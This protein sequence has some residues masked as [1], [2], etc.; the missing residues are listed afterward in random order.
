MLNLNVKLWRQFQLINIKKLL[1]PINIKRLMLLLHACSIRTAKLYFVLSKS[2]RN[3][4]SSVKFTIK[5]ACVWLLAEI[6]GPKHD[7]RILK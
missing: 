1:R 3:V 4:N 2:K 7:S 6:T 5:N